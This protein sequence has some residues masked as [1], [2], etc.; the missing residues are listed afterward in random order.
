MGWRL[1]RINTTRKHG[2]RVVAGLASTYD[3]VPLIEVTVQSGGTLIRPLNE[4]NKQ[5]YL[6]SAVSFAK[7]FTPPY[8]G[9]G[10]EINS[11]YEKSPEDFDEFV[12]FYNNVYYA[13]KGVSPESAVF[14]VFQL[15]LMKG[16]ML[17]S[18]EPANP[19]N[20]Q[21]F[22]LD[23][24][25]TDLY[26]FTTYPGLVHKDPL[27]IPV[28]YY[29]EISEYVSKPIIF[30]ELGWHS[31]ESP[32]G[33]ESSIE[34]QAEFVNTFFKLTKNL[35]ME[36]AIWSFLYD[37]ETIEPFRSMGMRNEDGSVRPA[38]ESWLSSDS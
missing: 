38:W 14:T 19:D 26:A 30:T 24:F 10:I 27:D 6:D 17:W 37:P 12:E 5:M 36:I 21:W 25:Q 16:H 34:E 23:R 13:V 31:E 9:L 15:E 1:A 4:S 7:E 35:D 22:L 18:D 3:Y 33:W 29:D 11:V 20:A 8:L 2:P 28:D 32:M